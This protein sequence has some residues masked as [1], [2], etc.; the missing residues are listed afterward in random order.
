MAERAQRQ[1]IVALFVLSGAAGLMYEVVWARQLV[2][3]FGNTTQAVS[4]ILTGFFGG[5]AIGAYAGGRLAD[6]V[7]SPLRVYA[8]AEIALACVAVLTP[9]LFSLIRE[10][11]RSAFPDL[12]GNS[13]ALELVKFGLAVLA[14]A[15]ATILMGATLPSLTRHLTRSIDQVGG[16]FGRL[17][18]AN[19]MG[20]IAG[21]MAAGYLL[22]ELIGLQA[23]VW[24]A[25]T[26]SLSA[27]LAGFLLSFR[28][29]PAISAQRSRER[30]EVASPRPHRALVLTV[31]FI[32]GLTSL[33]YQVLWT[34]LMSSATDN[35]SY[36]FTTILVMFLTGIAL[37]AYVHGRG[38]GRR[39]G[40]LET[41][42][43]SQLSIAAIA[44]LGLPFM[45]EPGS[46]TVA[47][48]AIILPA[49]AVMGFALPVAAGL[50]ANDEHR[51][52]SDSGLLLAVNTA[53][54]VVG[55]FIV[56]FF[57]VRAFGSG[58][59][60][61]LL[62]TTNALL[63]SLLF[64]VVSGR[65]PALRPMTLVGATV[66]AAIVILPLLNPGITESPTARRV[67][68]EGLLFASTE[69]E[70]A[71]VQAGQLDGEE[72]LWVAGMSMTHVTVDTKLMPLLPL[73]ARPESESALIV[74]FGMGTSHR[75]ALIA[76]LRVESI[77]LVPSVP[78][79]FG[80]YHADAAKVLADPRGRVIIADGRNFVALSDASY[81]MVLA[82]PPP[83]IRSAGT[84]VLYAKEFYEACKA[85]L[86]PGG[87]MMQWMPHDQTLDEF[88]AHMRTFDS[89]F[90]HVTYVLSL[91]GNGVF[92]LG[93]DEPMD[94]GPDAIRAMLA[95]PGVLADLDATR[96]APVTN[97][98]AW[99][100]LMDS[101][102]WLSED[103][104][105]AFAGEGPMITDDRPLT[106]YFLLRGLDSQTSPRNSHEVLRAASS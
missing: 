20:G 35:S 82:D 10:T 102:I 37:G 65:K 8:A 54:T 33:G 51:I 44:F 57:L 103:E 70:I 52:G 60:V 76:G 39:F 36:V 91:A 85:R 101:L 87:V 56:P 95:R 47:W 90:R 74:A 29:T 22:I 86:S 83:P 64:A 45:G 4:A 55:T 19:T 30:P 28:L 106:E 11:Y 79:M 49:T 94:V 67:S 46:A 75:S 13:I 7:R 42:A 15:P 97:P 21:T 93:S 40:M 31:A 61:L 24:V 66:A 50:L 3:V 27:G 5:M 77:E 105:R 71:S 32:S 9:V 18:A 62:A 92:M 26:A 59:S 6:R 69:D 81:D 23:T 1:V 99:A 84:G 80:Y 78:E 53:G 34:R 38:L 48:L 73:A 43:V 104:A 88:R 2:L 16:Q 96:D 98:G 17:Y 14:V 58:W 12:A 72:R 89:V 68:R 41:L 25:A 100:A 63:G